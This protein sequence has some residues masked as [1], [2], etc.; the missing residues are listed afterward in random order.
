MTSNADDCKCVHAAALEWEDSCAQSCTCKVSPLDPFHKHKCSCQVSSWAAIQ[1][2]KLFSAIHCKIF[3]E[4]ERGIAANIKVR[5][6]LLHS[7]GACRTLPT[8]FTAITF[9]RPL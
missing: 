2:Q 3:Q 1:D 7:W 9:R 6:G 4:V 5:A 8:S